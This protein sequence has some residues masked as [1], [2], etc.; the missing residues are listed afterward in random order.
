MLTWH[1]AGAL[2]S[3]LQLLLLVL[4]WEGLCLLRWNLFPCCL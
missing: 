4:P 2:P 1:T 3:K